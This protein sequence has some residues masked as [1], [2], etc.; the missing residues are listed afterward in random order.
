LLKV[1]GAGSVIGGLLRVV[2]S[3]V[4]TAD[5]Q[6]LLELLYI[7]TDLCLILGLVGIYV[8]HRETLPAYGHIGF[9]IALCGLSFITGPEAEIYGMGAYQIGTPVIGTGIFLLALSQL[10]RASYPDAAPTLLLASIALGG[11][12]MAIPQYPIIFAVCGVLFGLGFILNGVYIC[13][14]S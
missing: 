11:V 7:A 1:F 3:F 6:S 2:S 14:N 9:I 10:R 5:D 13:R 4:T 12:A 8:I